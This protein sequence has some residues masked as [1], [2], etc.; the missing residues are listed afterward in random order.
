V[1]PAA[2]SS[3]VS[4]RMSRQAVRDTTPE[5]NL[6][7]EL[8]ALGLRYRLH[9]SVVPELRRSADIVFVRA[10]V[11]VFV[12]GC[13][14]HGCAEHKSVPRANA[15]WWTQK[16]ARNKERDTETDDRLRAAGW[17]PLRVWEHEDPE[18]AAERV[19]GIVADRAND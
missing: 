16:I 19:A 4:R 11:A 14:W 6:R 8:S 15:E 2:S 17:I 1:R 10:R 18:S 9:R 3:S 5:M 13:F 7:R 12:D